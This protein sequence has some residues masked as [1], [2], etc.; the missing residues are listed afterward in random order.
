MHIKF[1]SKRERSYNNKIKNKKQDIIRDI[2]E[3]WKIIKRNR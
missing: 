3:I 2:N 1:S